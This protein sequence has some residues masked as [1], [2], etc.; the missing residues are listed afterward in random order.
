M[1]FILIL[2]L[3]FKTVSWLSKGFT[4]KISSRSNILLNILF[5]YFRFILD[6]IKE[7]F[8]ELHR[9]FKRKAS[10]VGFCFKRDQLC[11]NVIAVEWLIFLLN[12]LKILGS[13]SRHQH[14]FRLASP[15]SMLLF[16]LLHINER[17]RFI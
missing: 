17:P 6:W 11:V 5:S 14:F 15:I 1:H 12:V 2:Q 7:S 3:H 8:I 10:D 16:H 9:V 4:F 13:W